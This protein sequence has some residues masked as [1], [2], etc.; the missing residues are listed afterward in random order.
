MLVKDEVK[1]NL[2]SQLAY[3]HLRSTSINL[4]SVVNHIFYNREKPFQ[5]WIEL[6]TLFSD[7]LTL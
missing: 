7:S 2:M 1:C 5:C 4:L 6:N 3:Q